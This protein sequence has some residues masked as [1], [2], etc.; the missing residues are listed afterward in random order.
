MNRNVK[1]GLLFIIILL[2]ISTVVGGFYAYE[3]M[4]NMYWKLAWS[5]KK[6]YEETHGIIIDFG[7]VPNPFS[8]LIP[9]VLLGL[10]LTIVLLIDEVRQ[11][12]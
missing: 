9:L 3:Q 10:F 2:Q 12:R 4:S 8:P 1:V 11:K 6:L 5:Y 7:L